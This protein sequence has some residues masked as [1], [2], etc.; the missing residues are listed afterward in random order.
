MSANSGV[1][2]AIAAFCADRRIRAWIPKRSFTTD[3][4]AMV[5]M[6]G[7]MRIK[8]GERGDLSLPPYART[9]L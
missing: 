3:N 8:P 6:A 1:R 5:A 4:A 7:A 2:E 9:E